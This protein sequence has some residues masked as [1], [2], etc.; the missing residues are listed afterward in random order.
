[1]TQTSPFRYD[2]VGSFLRPEKLKQ[3]RKEFA[4]EKIS[5]EALTAVEDAAIKELIQQQVAA[6]L[7]AVT[8]GEYRRSWWH[9]DFMWGLNGIAKEYN[10]SGNKFAAMNTRSETAR[11]HGKITGENHPF[12]EHYKFLI[13]NTPEGIEARQTVPAPAQFVQESLRK[14]NLEFTNA[15]YP[16]IDDLVE[17]LAAAY[18]TVLNDLY[19]A[20]CRT[21]QFDDC[22]WGRLIGG[23]FYDGHQLTEEELVYL[24]D[25]YVRANNAAIDGKPEGMNIVTHVCRGNY[26]STWFASGAYTSVA[27][28]LFDQENVHAYYLEFDSDRAGGFEPLAKVTPGKKVVLGL[29]TSKSPELE[30][31]ADVIAR[32]K[33]ASQFVPLENLCLSTQCG[34]SSTEEGNSLTE[35]E[36]WAKI[37]LVKEI[38]EEV[39]G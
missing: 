1:M 33:E 10:E 36:Q 22:T 5:K 4:E 28:P 27:T 39:W 2:I 31:K 17:D 12:V 13:A 24:K 34:F 38:A 3:A 29:I 32:I 15:V 20:G 25:L 9:F 26:R 23:E 37:K 21:V 11:I 8:D 18:H 6:G 35:A 19:A 30:N 14:S 7:K 16:E